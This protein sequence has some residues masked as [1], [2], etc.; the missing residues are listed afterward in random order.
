MAHAFGTIDVYGHDGVRN[1]PLSLMG[2]NLG[3]LSYLDAW[4]QI[5]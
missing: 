2:A 3:T 1:G 5:G 4:Q